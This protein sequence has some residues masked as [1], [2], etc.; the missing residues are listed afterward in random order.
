MPAERVELGYRYCTKPRCQAVH[1]RGVLVT[2]IGVNKGAD[3]IVVGD[4]DEI[5][6]RGEA[7]EL[8][9]KDTSL[10]LDYRAG[11]AMPRTP[12]KAVRKPGQTARPR[13]WTAEQERA[14]RLYHEMGLNPRQVAERAASNTP[15]LRITERLAT[16]IMSTLPRRRP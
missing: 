1:H 5:R 16:Q 15:R 14:V 10:G 12:H 6:R 9:K 4:P 8:A 7:G 2:A 11:H 3:T 13:P